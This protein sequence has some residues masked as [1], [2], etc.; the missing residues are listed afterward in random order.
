MGWGLPTY[1]QDHVRKEVGVGCRKSMVI[2]KGQ[3]QACCRHDQKE[4]NGGMIRRNG[5]P[6]IL[7]S[8]AE[9]ISSVSAEAQIGFELERARTR[10]ISIVWS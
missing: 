6:S 7:Y 9:K 10:T 2:L 3:E 4:K 1:D 8:Q 5:E